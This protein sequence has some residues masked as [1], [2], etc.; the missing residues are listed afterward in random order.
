MG[1]A[2]YLH[3]QLA[4]QAAADEAAEG[5]GDGPQL[6]AW[7]VSG[8]QQQHHPGLYKAQGAAAVVGERQANGPLMARAI[9]GLRSPPRQR[10][11]GPS[12]S[13]DGSREGCKWRYKKLDVTPC[14]SA[15]AARWASWRHRSSDD[16][17]LRRASGG[18]LTL[19]HLAAVSAA[20]AVLSVLATLR[21]MATESPGE[22]SRGAW[23]FAGPP[24]TN[25]H[26]QHAAIADGY[27]DVPAFI[28]R[29]RG[30][31][32]QP[33]PPQQQQQHLSKAYAER[34]ARELEKALG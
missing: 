12:A 25:P 19:T 11:E 20:R 28:A 22:S 21:S 24:M 2:Q 31:R 4:R 8:Q 32:A 27:V 7:E 9:V 23:T 34:F 33:R 1:R 17:S 30:S 3:L 18:E 5:L 16:L 13:S 10:Q 6:R 29:L 26:W 15:G 14:E